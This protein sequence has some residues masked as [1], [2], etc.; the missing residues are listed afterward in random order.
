MFEATFGP[1][2]SV[3]I[4]ADLLHAWASWA[5]DPASDA[6]LWLLNGSPAGITVDFKLDG[7]L[8]PVESETPL[9][10]DSLTADS[11]TFTNYDGVESDPEALSIIDGYIRNGWIAEF[12]SLDALRKNVGGEPVLNKFACIKKTKLDG[13]IK[14]RIIM[15]SKRSSV[16]E[17]SKKMYKAVLPRA[18]DLVHD[19]LAMLADADTADDVEIFICDAK[20]AFWQIQLHPDERRFY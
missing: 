15:D 17:A 20:D 12:S 1:S 2:Q 10:I 11:D 8:E 16:T 7:V 18:T 9:G 19:A 5:G 3:D 6:A 13:T 4:Q 14:R